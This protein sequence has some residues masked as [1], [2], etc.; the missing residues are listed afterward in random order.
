MIALRLKYLLFTIIAFSSTKG[1]T[2][3]KYGIELGYAFPKITEEKY[4]SHYINNGEDKLT[5]TRDY[6]KSPVIGINADLSI[7]K[8]L[9]FSFGAQYQKMGMLYHQNRV[10]RNTYTNYTYTHDWW[11]S[12]TFQKICFPLGI[13]I[14]MNRWK[15]SPSLLV[16]IRTNYLLIGQYSSKSI[17]DYSVDSLDGSFSYEFNPVD[18][19]ETSAPAKRLQI[20]TFYGFSM[21]LGKSVKL[22]FTANSGGAISYSTDALSCFLYSCPN[23]D[24]IASITF[25]MPHKKKKPICTLKC[26]QENY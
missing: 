24:Y 25:F 22:S 1:Q 23:S 2:V 14:R 4:E 21:F 16:G 15:F 3:F 7:K 5:T 13:G 9:Y 6:I 11:L 19:K 17:H 12:Q 10:G 8:H 18:L 26:I 20:Q